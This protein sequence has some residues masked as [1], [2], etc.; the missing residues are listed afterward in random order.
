MQKFFVK[1]NQIKDDKIEI[2]GTDVN[3][4]INVLRMRKED[5]VQIN[6]LSTSENYIAEIIEYSKERILCKIIEKL[7]AKSETKID[8]DLYQ[9]LPK[10]DK[11]E[12]II[13]KTTEIGVKKI[14]PVSMERSIVK[15]NEKDS[16]K[17]IERWQKIAEVAA[18]QS[19]R[20][21]I[22][23]IEKLMNINNVC[24][25]I[26]N[27]DLFLI[28]YEDEH[29]NKLKEILNKNKNVS[30][31]GVIVGPE[32]GFD[33]S[34]IEKLTSEGAIAVTLGNRILRTETAPIVILSNIVYELEDL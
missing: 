17:K 18:K 33:K 24:D 15:L 31:V 14:I 30:K 5:V 21:I 4:I 12:L 2:T 28:A 1:E 22:P 32:G 11:M 34:E 13:Q 7:D 20:D 26:K 6:N 27:Y 16:N 9:G 8:I 29:Q 19:K 3:H 23:K 25:N 10:A